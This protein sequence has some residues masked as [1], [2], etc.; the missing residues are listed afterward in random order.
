MLARVFALVFV[1]LLLPAFP[2]QAGCKITVT[3][4]GF[5]STGCAEDPHTDNRA[6]TG[7]TQDHVES[8]AGRLNTISRTNPN[9]VTVDRWTENGD[10]TA[11]DKLTGLIWELKSGAQ[12]ASVVYVDKA[13]C[14]D[15]HDSNNLYS[16]STGSPWNFDGTVATVVLEQL[17]TEPCFGNSCTWRLPTIDELQTLIEPAS[18]DCS[19]QP[20][21]T[22]PGETRAN[23]YWSSSVVPLRTVRIV[24]FFSGAATGVRMTL[25]YWARAVRDG[26]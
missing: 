21:T 22:I 15:P 4:E 12:A 3:S 14:P 24:T 5:L 23:V 8:I 1:A 7:A 2:A 13:T 16:W 17:N 10:G 25:N 11:T 26:P 6:A 20:C 19:V 18:P 9:G